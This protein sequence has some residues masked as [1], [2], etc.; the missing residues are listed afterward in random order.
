MTI[1][2]Y[3]MLH[4]FM[5][6][7]YV[8]DSAFHD[9]LRLTDLHDWTPVGLQ[10]TADATGACF[11]EREWWFR[12]KRWLVNDCAPAVPSDNASPVPPPQHGKRIRT[13]TCH[14]QMAT[15]DFDY[16]RRPAISAELQTLNCLSVSDTAYK[17]N[18]G[19]CSLSYGATN[20]SR[21]TGH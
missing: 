18:C 10:L 11:H 2:I 1:V 15:Q 17:N 13:L 20:A 8:E 19:P 5:V 21:H 7:I 16:A 9:L 12:L 3:A 6:C 14:L 4:V